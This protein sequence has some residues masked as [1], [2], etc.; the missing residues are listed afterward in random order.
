MFS[1]QT[2]IRHAVIVLSCS[3]LCLELAGTQIVCAQEN[4]DRNLKIALARQPKQPVEIDSP[5]SAEGCTIAS[6]KRLYGT[7]GFVVRDPAGLIV[8]MYAKG[9]D[10]KS[11]HWTF[12]KNGEEVYREI[13][14][15]GDSKIDEYRWLG[16]AG[17]RWGVD[18]KGNG[19]IDFWKVI[20]AEEVA[21]E[22]F[23]ALKTKDQIRFARLCL[24]NRDLEELSLGSSMRAKVVESV[25]ATFD[26]LKNDFQKNSIAANAEFVDFGG[27]RPSVVPEGKFGLDQDLTIY[28][29]VATLYSGTNRIEQISLGTLIKVGDCWRIIEPSVQAGGNSIN[30][31]FFVMNTAAEDP[32]PVTPANEKLTALMAEYT[33]LDEKF[34]QAKGTLKSRMY[35]E[36]NSLMLKIA[37]ETSSEEDRKLWIQMLASEASIGYQTGEYPSGLDY[38]Q[39]LVKNEIVKDEASFVAWEL[40]QAKAVDTREGSPDDRRA[41]NDAY[42]Q[43]LED[44]VADYP[45]AEKASDAILTLGLFEEFS[46][47][48]Q[49]VDRAKT[50]YQKAAER[51]GE[52]RNGKFAEGAMRRLDAFGSQLEISGTSLSGKQVN[53]ANFRNRQIVVVHYWSTQDPLS[54]EDFETLVR[55][56]AKFEDELEIIGINLDEDAQIAKTYLRDEQPKAS[57]QHLWAAGGREDSPFALYLGV[58]SVPLTILIDQSGEVAESQI[59]TE[60]LDREIYRLIRRNK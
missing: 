51:F 28:D 12:F 59:A 60:Q 4:S 30:G 1:T 54:L 48:N 41:A 47:S 46:S 44:Y 37:A 17:T 34:R 10:N 24:G 27:S 57:W 55:M 15:D 52:T 56:E 42:L 13:D 8:R 20:S 33:E 29:N 31:R 3:W 22:A 40:I 19:K 18:T 16:E 9:A 58:T 2:K 32:G 21:Y 38:L 39:K 25:N 43:L 36:R 53:L 49:S 23:E 50:W 5:D 45:T 7:E 6:A 26:W 11:T 14:T 35:P